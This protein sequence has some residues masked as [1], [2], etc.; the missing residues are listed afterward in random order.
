MRELWSWDFLQDPSKALPCHI[1]NWAANPNP[2]EGAM[3]RRRNRL[4]SVNAP[5]ASFLITLIQSI[6]DRHVLWLVC[7]NP[8]LGL[9]DILM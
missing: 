5:R 7:F 2:S 9:R 8:S 1:I 3:P 6:Q 4:V